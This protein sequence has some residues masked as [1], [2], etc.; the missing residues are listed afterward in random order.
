MKVRGFKADRIGISG[1]TIRG[2]TVEFVIQ[3]VDNDGLVHGEVTHRVP[4]SEN[5]TVRDKVKDLLNEL[6]DY[7]ASKHFDQ[8]ETQSTKN[9]EP[10]QY[11]IA[12]LLSHDENDEPG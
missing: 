6:L 9:R 7:S 1:L 4:L 10:L 3:Y 8:Y 5:P 2:S 12:E 11:G